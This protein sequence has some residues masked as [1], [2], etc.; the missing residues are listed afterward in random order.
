MVKIPLDYIC[1]KSG[2]LCPRCQFLVDSGRVKEYEVDVMKALIEL[3]E[4]GV[5]YLKDAEYHKS[6]REDNILV[7][8]L[9]FKQKIPP[10]EL[11]KLSRML[12]SK[13][14][15]RVKVVP[16]SNDVRQLAT[17]ILHPARILGINTVWLPD[18]S[19]HY[20]IRV[21]RSD[22]RIISHTRE[23]Y[24]KILSEIIGQEVEIRVTDI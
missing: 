8:V 12:S 19:T 1:V 10:H 11:G 13:L 2:I 15:I 4:S 23:I 20:V 5:R 21:P 9:S 6:Y 3:E 14:N 16:K 22:Y 24:E 17:L 7:I 18:G